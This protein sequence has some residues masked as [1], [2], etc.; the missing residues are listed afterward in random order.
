[1]KNRKKIGIVTIS[2]NVPNYGQRLQC[3][4]VQHLLSQ[5]GYDSEMIQDARWYA[6]PILFKTNWKDILHCIIRY[7][8][9]PRIHGFRTMIY[10]WIK[11]NLKVSKFY[12]NKDEDMECLPHMYDGFVVGSDQVWNPY[13]STRGLNSFTTLQFAPKEQRIAY[14]AS[15]ASYDI[16]KERVEEFKDYLK[17]FGPISMR[18]KSGA[19]IIKQLLNRDV[20]VVLDPTLMRTGDEWAAEFVRKPKQTGYLIL[21]VYGRVV[22]D[23]YRK[24]AEELAKQKGLQLLC[25]NEMPNVLDYSV[26]SWLGYV[27]YADYVVTNSFHCCVFSILFHKNISAFRHPIIEEQMGSRIVDLF[28]TL[29]L[30]TKTSALGEEKITETMVE[31]WGK[32]ESILV[33]ERQKAMQYLSSV[34]PPLS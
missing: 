27:K 7:H 4:M 24:K 13:F 11:R 2:E 6:N 3:Y 9:N 12:V 34:F 26:E 22:R 14:A 33:G 18:E 1:M 10:L 30:P 21:F 29:Q 20:P 28:E 5:L 23:E 15:I 31:D 16:P 19:K 25:L 32:V 17:D 8:L